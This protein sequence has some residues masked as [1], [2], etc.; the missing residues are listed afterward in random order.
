M[1]TA[2]IYN[3]N[4]LLTFFYLHQVQEGDRMTAGFREICFSPVAAESPPDRMYEIRSVL[5]I[6]KF[7]HSGLV[8]RANPGF[9]EGV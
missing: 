3:G 2:L 4:L 8:L 6:Y 5:K 7:I 9:I 1:G